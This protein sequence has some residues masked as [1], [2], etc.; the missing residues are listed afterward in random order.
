M[1]RSSIVVVALL[2]VGCSTGPT[3]PSGAPS[4]SSGVVTS[5]A[6]APSPRATGE[7]SPAPTGSAEASV[8][9][10]P[11]DVADP[12]GNPPPAGGPAADLTSVTIRRAADRLTVRFEVSGPVP[13]TADS[14]LW[15]V[16]LDGDE[17]YTVAAQ[18]TGGEL[19]A[20]VYDHRRDVQHALE[21]VE[22][23]G[24]A[25]TVHVPGDELEELGATFDW[26]ASTQLDGAYEDR[27]A[28]ATLEGSSE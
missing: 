18:L 23:D 6:S 5:S 28:T 11:G 4:A 21:G 13:P 26:S 7:P 17:R 14:L 1:S 12:E 9:D 24:A 22:V 8:P 27:T 3:A 25:I 20:G 2:V 16:E 19:N 10:P 15:S